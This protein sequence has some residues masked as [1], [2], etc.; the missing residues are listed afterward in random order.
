ML[1]IIIQ[2]SGVGLSM[3]TTSSC[4]LV[5]SL[6]ATTIWRVA[7]KR[8]NG[9]ISSFLELCDT[10]KMNGIDQNI[11]YM[12]LFPF[13]LKD[14]ATTRLKLYQRDWLSLGRIWCINSWQSSSL[15]KSH[16]SLWLRLV[17]SSKVKLRQCMMHR[18]DTKTYLDIVHIMIFNYGFRLKLLL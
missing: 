12:R 4:L 3:P 9:H 13:S 5:L 17:S 16:H 8:P 2:V 6:S 1:L 15:H 10:V 14:K 11:I 18:I 7:F